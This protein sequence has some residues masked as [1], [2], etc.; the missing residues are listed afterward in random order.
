M[1]ENYREK[2][3]VTG[4]SK[5]SGLNQKYIFGGIERFKNCIHGKGLSYSAMIGYVIDDDYSNWLSRI[6]A[7]I[8]E[9]IIKNDEDRVTWKE[10]DK[11]IYINNQL[12]K[13]PEWKLNRKKVAK[14]I[15]ENTRTEDINCKG[16]IIIYHLWIKI[17]YHN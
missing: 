3:Y 16:A 1:T 9:L 15:S 2:E 7:W 5:K 6:N 10:C 12:N 4:Y 8:D 17:E 14:L 11:L 13:L